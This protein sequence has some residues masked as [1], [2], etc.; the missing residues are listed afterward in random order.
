M[1]SEKGIFDLLI[2]GAGPSGLACAIEARQHGLSTLLLDKG[3]VADAIRRF[4]TFLT[5]F[6]TPELLQIADLPF[7]VS[8]F[9]PTRVDCLRYYQ[10]VARHYRL[11]VRSGEKVIGLEKGNGSFSVRTQDSLFS[12]RNVVVAT[13]Y[14][15]HPNPYNVPGSH[16][17]KVHRYY[18]EPFEYAGKE[19]AVV[20]GR[21]SAVE[22]ALDLFRN[23]AKV[24]LIHRGLKL[25]DGVKY[26]ILPDLENR[27]KS[28]EIR[29]LFGTAVRE[30]RKDVIRTEGEHQLKLTYDALFVMI[31]YRP[32]NALL[33]AVGVEVQE[34]S[35][36]PVHDPGTMETNVEGLFVAG[37]I[38]A[39]KLNNKIFIENGREHGK[40]IVQ[41]ITHS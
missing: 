18:S 23:G 29:A 14:F 9:R 22:V 15:D 41:K 28:G 6:S 32:D 7:V 31:G 38:A 13:G 40:L 39:G 36:A 10:T 12:A 4:P 35:L 8:S 5:F 30:I 17:S 1:N 20:G 19:V 3:S 34:D 33:Q 11:P 37:S 2:V 26:W 27:I 25:S 21:N 24:T 16:L